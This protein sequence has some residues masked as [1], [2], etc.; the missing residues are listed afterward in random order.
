MKAIININLE[1]EYPKD[2]ITEQQKK[3][4]LENVEL[5][6]NYVVDS[7]EFVKDVQE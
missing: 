6:S 1:F 7:F 4:F 5:P 2:C 3:E